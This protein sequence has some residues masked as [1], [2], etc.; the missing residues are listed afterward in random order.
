MRAVA[1]SG[2]ADLGEHGLGVL[3]PGPQ[4]LEVEHPRPPRRPIAI[5]VAG[6]TTES[7]GAAMRGR[8]KVNASIVHDTLTSSG[9][10]VRRLG[11][12]ATSSKA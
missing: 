2:S 3:V 6:L 9:S 5:A 7:I 11:T 8:P 12:M 1:P 10:R 4:A